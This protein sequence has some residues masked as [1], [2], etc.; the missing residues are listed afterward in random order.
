M[1]GDVRRV[2]IV[3]FS[4][5]GNTE[6][7][8]GLFASEFRARGF[9]AELL[10]VE[11]VLYGGGFDPGRYSVIGFGYCVHA[12]NAPSIVYRL[13]GMLPDGGGKK[14][15]VFKCPG[16][17]FMRGGSTRML[18]NSLKAKGYD[19]FHESLIATPSNVVL[20]MGDGLVKRL[21]AVAKERVRVFCGEIL[22]GERRLQDNP[23]YLRA[24]SRA[25]SWGE[26]LGARFFGRLQLSASWDCAGCGGCASICPTRNIRLEKG[27]PVFGWECIMCMRC[28]YLCPSRAI[29]AGIFEGFALKD[30]CSMKEVISS[31]AKDNDWKL[32]WLLSPDFKRYVGLRP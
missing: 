18:R 6:L 14:T 21:Y 7:V 22:V 5:T 12:F 3:Y 24:I 28:I 2:G 13:V 8:A 32:H 19:V 4:G 31:P 25:F 20:R 29:H 30:W 9:E 23:F 11:D 10:R 15:F 27:R 1:A 26:T 17:P 16:D